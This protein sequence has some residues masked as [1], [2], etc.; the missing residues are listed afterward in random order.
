[1]K[2]SYKSSGKEGIILNK[3]FEGTLGDGI[4]K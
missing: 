3:D 4:D 2:E 1:M